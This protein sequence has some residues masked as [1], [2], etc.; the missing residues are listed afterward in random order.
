[1]WNSTVRER[2]M[3]LIEL[4]VA[5][6]II[7]VGLAGVLSVFQLNVRHSAD[8]MVNKQLLALAEGLLNEVMLQPFDV[9]PG[10]EGPQGCRRDGF[11]D[12]GDFA[13]YEGKPACDI[14]GNEILPG[15]TLSVI[16]EDAPLGMENGA[17][18]SKR[19]TVTA[20]RNPQE[21]VSVVSW[22]SGWAS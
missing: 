18:A 9:Q 4:I 2:G 14:E 10:P 1:M 8:P 12:L 21:N 20:T 15:Y 13:G 22:R 7:S 19:I 17:P 16:I 3:T 6:V 5:M 11:N